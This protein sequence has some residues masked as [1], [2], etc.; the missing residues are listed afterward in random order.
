MPNFP[1]SQELQDALDWCNGVM[2]EY[3]LF[4]ESPNDPRSYLSLSYKGK[5]ETLHSVLLQIQ[6]YISLYKTMGL[7]LNINCSG[8][9]IFIESIEYNMS[10]DR[11]YQYGMSPN[12]GF[13]TTY[14]PIYTHQYPPMFGEYL[15]SSPMYITTE[16][17][18]KSARDEEL[19]N[20]AKI[21]ADIDD[22]EWKA[23]SEELR[24]L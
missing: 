1:Y 21:A 24:K 9:R 7:Y 3:N 19:N 8:N 13:S 6:S 18:P 2:S 23:F 17:L 20:L 4:L 14:N 16:Y 15:V 12:I 5:T 11:P 10:Y 22:P